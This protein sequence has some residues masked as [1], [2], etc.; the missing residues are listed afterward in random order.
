MIWES[1]WRRNIMVPYRKG[2]QQRCDG[3]VG[4]R[5][6]LDKL[7][8]FRIS[9]TFV[10]RGP[11]GIPLSEATAQDAGQLSC[12][13]SSSAPSHP[14]RMVCQLIHSQGSWEYE[15]PHQAHCLGT[16]SLPPGAP[17]PLS[18]TVK[19]S[20]VPSAKKYTAL[21]APA[22]ISGQLGPTAPGRR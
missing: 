19:L 11:A 22:T 8:N 13:A 18:S 20:A 14:D 5:E 10:V 21:S 7:S 3:S 12:S 1:S 16:P 2:A 6:G 15:M 4:N 17:Y 9:D